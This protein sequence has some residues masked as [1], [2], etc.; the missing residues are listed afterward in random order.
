MEFDP[1]AASN[2]VMLR[3]YLFGMED[4]V[5]LVHGRLCLL[6]FFTPLSG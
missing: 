6:D 5:K 2:N 3:N 1:F 4:Y